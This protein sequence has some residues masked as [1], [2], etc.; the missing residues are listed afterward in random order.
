MIAI[1]FI[2]QYRKALGL[3][4]AA[5]LC[6]LI[7]SGLY[8]TG[9]KHGKTEAQNTYKDTVIS[10][11]QGGIEAMQAGYNL[12]V[13]IQAQLDK[14]AQRYETHKRERDKHQQHIYKRMM[15]YVSSQEPD[16]CFIH[17]DARRLLLEAY[18][19]YGY[20]TGSKTCN[21]PSAA[22]PQ[23]TEPIDLLTR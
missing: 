6:L 22:M 19:T 15:D 21:Q 23:L 14:A 2:Y 7:L 13:A 3:A 1:R 20:D 18:C 5:V 8:N 9:F 4:L 10:E 17:D 12:N 16:N 11:L